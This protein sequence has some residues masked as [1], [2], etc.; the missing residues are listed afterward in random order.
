MLFYPFA[1]L[2]SISAIVF[3]G[4]IIVMAIMSIIDIKFTSKPAYLV[5]WGVAM[6]AFGV[7]AK[8]TL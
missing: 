5:G 6:I 2:T 3:F 1:L 8:M 7:I 4:A